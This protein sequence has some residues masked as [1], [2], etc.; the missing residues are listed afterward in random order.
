MEETVTMV[1][2]RI[3]TITREFKWATA[4]NKEG[5]VHRESM[6]FNEDVPRKAVTAETI[7][8]ALKVKHLVLDDARADGLVSE[9]EHL[10]LLKGGVVQL[11][12]AMG[13]LKDVKE[14]YTDFAE[15]NQL[16]KDLFMELVELGIIK[17]KQK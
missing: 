17:K 3:T 8:L 7:L 11:K 1:H 2:E 16:A 5:Y 15:A 9:E 14:D 4:Y 12:R 10:D 6:Q 13:Y